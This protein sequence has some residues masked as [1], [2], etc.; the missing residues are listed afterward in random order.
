MIKNIGSFIKNK[1]ALAVGFLFA[2]SSL[3]FGTWVAA[4]PGIKQRLNFTDGSLGLSLLLSPLGAITGMLLSTRIFSKIPVG[5]WMLNGYRVLCLLMILQINS[6][7]RPMFW[8]CLYLYGLCSFL[9]GVSSNATV[10]L[11]EKKADR[12]FMSTCHGMYSLG[13]AVSA[14]LAALLIS[15]HVIAGWQIVLI[16]TIIFTIITANQKQLL[17]HQEIIHSRSGIKLPSPAILGISFICMVTFMAEGCVADWSAIYLKESLN[18]PKAMISLGYAGFSI[19]M[20]LGRLNGDSLIAAIGNKKI[21]I[22]GCL[23]SALG[24]TIVVLASVVPAAITGYILIGCGSSCIIPVLFSAAAN[25]PGTSTVEGFAM[26]TTGGLIGFLA[27]PSLIGF[28]SEKSNLSKGLSL[29]IV[30]ALLAAIVAWKN[31]FFTDKKVKAAALEY[32]EQ[33]Y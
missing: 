9:N 25:I 2:T 19:A 12:L 22:A 32:D 30:M 21:V 28:I 1:P 10:N 23:L 15:F 26:V 5:R 3:L 13:G 18:A 6:V 11:M 4:I 33:I 29:L 20:T 8:L 7:N 14:G 27:G 31:R 16:A 24:F 17:V